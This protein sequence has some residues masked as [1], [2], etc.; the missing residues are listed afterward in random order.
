MAIEI[1]Q[2]LN[3]SSAPA[4]RFVDQW[5]RQRRF[6]GSKDRREIKD[7][8]YTVMR[9]RR[10]LAWRAR[11]DETDFRLTTIAA[12]AHGWGWSHSDFEAAFDGQGYG[13]PAL[14]ENEVEIIEGFEARD[15][16]A[17][18]MPPAVAGNFP[19]WLASD[20]EARF[21]ADLGPEITALNGRAPVDLRVNTLKASLDDARAALLAEGVEAET[22]ELSPLALRLGERRRITGTEAFRNGMVEVQDEA[23]QVASLLVDARPG[24]Q[25]ADVCAGA[26]GKSLA[27][28]AAMENSG[29]IQAW[30]VD[31]A[32]LERLKERAVRAGARNIQTARIK[33][34]GG[35][36]FE[37]MAGRFDRVLLDLLCSGT[38]TWRRNPESK[39]RLDAETL[40]RQILRQRDI[41]QRA[42][43]LVK[44]GGRLVYATCSVLARENRDQINN[45]LE[46]HADFRLLPVADIWPVALGAAPTPGEC[47]ELSPHRNNTDG[48]FTAVLEKIE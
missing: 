19:D 10:D 21:G 14:S 35:G 4:D 44:P 38:G 31:S 1:L 39:W 15:A 32:R 28:A 16:E 33:A 46:L 18:T 25:V 9:R 26:G 2:A 43:V 6:A 48:F 40:D 17:D 47:L 20:L 3:A 11:C 45:F 5:F 24:M 42:A 7:L 13:P 8:V 37:Q 29:Q 36:L 30:D 22:C 41:S 23:A 12:L 34:D 27:L